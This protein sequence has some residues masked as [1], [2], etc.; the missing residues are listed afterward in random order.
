[1]ASESLRRDPTFEEAVSIIVHSKLVNKTF[2]S[3][4]TQIDKNSSQ[5]LPKASS[6]DT[7]T[8][9]PSTT[10]T[11][12]QSLSVLKEAES[13]ATSPMDTEVDDIIVRGTKHKRQ[14]L[15]EYQDRFG[16]D[17]NMPI[18]TRKKGKTIAVPT[19]NPSVFPTIKR[20]NQDAPSTIE[21]KN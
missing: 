10:T 17:V 5:V 21:L 1:M 12:V 16:T 6:R 9:C 4:P 2:V 18:V 8:T 3:L 13:S 15:Q 19:N 11:K 20:M 7:A 14:I